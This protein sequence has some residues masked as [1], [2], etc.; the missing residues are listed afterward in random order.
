MLGLRVQVE[1]RGELSQ[2]LEHCKSCAE[3]P[4]KGLR[5]SYQARQENPE[6]DFTDV[7]TGNLNKNYF[8]SMW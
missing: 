3:E 1:K 2:S 4:E 7:Y 6:S 8:L 5:K